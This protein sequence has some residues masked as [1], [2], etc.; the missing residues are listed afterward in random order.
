MCSF[1]LRAA[2]LRVLVAHLMLI[3]L[4]ASAVVVRC[5]PP[6]LAQSSRRSVV[7]GYRHPTARTIADP[8]RRPL[9]P[10]S[11]GNRGL[12]YATSPGDPLRA[13]GG[14]VV[15]FAGRIAGRM[16]VTVLHPDG[17]R[18]S[19]SYL[20]R[21]A[22]RRGDVVAAGQILGWAGT[23]NAH[24]GVRSGSLYLDPAVLFSHPRPRHA[25]L[26]SAARTPAVVGAR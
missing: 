16:Y 18:S 4:G 11:A 12:E 7:V 21:L 6:A 2:R 19:T 1:Q 8:F 13:I 5:A 25:V 22:V 3:A 23:T 17:L 26:V 20:A 15:S 24:L 9:N 14:G 10:F